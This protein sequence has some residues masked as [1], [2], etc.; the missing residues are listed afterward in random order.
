MR[1]AGFVYKAFSVV[2]VIAGVSLLFFGLG[3]SRSLGSDVSRFFN[4][5]PSDRSMWMLFGGVVLL[6]LGVVGLLRGSR[7]AS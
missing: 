6:I 2:L 7:A 5:T 3:A 1:K 4:G